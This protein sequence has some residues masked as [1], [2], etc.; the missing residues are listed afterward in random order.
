[1]LWH[2]KPSDISGT[3]FIRSKDAYWQFPNDL[4]TTQPGVASNFHEIKFKLIKHI[5]HPY[6]FEPTPG[7]FI[8]SNVTTIEFYSLDSKRISVTLPND[9]P[10]FIQFRE[11]YNTT[12]GYG[13]EWLKCMSWDKDANSFIN[14]N[15]CGYQFL[16]EQI[17]CS[18]C[19]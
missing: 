5:L 11:P 8:E 7:A 14:D 19:N 15:S 17:P 3:I 1:M 6:M 4:F 2:R 9:S 16:W 13:G 12:R 10:N 18:D